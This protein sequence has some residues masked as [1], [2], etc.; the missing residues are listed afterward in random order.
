VKKF[1]FSPVQLQGAFDFAPEDHDQ[2]NTLNTA[3]TWQLAGDP[4]R[5]LTVGTTY[6]S[7]FPVQFENGPGR[8]AVHWELNGFSGARR[9]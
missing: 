1:L 9:R 5:Y 6:G 3:L 8:L 4:N 2:T 7:G